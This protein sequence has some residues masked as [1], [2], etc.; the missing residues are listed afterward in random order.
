MGPFGPKK[1]RNS[2]MNNSLKIKKMVGIATLSAIVIVLQLISNYVTI[3][4][5]SITLALIPIAM[6]AVLYGP[7]AGLILGSVMGVIVLTAPSTQGFIAFNVWYTII[8]CILKS[9]LGGLAAGFVYKGVIHIKALKQAKFSVAVILAC[10]VVPIINTGIFI[11]GTTTLF[12]D[13]ITGTQGAD[14]SLAFTTTISIVFT[15][16]FA[17]EF[18]LSCI[19]SPGFVY[20]GRILGDRFDLGFSK[21]FKDNAYLE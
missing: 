6:G 3:G 11:L 2:N 8:L 17:I 18:P 5:I 10:I 16:N 7:L 1:E 14:F 12:K 15:I 19:L 20:L 13:F 4:T 9:G 21:D